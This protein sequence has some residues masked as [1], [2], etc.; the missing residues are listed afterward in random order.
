MRRFPLARRG[1]PETGIEPWYREQ[2]G[3]DFRAT[4]SLHGA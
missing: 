4:G 3:L 1:V 2:K